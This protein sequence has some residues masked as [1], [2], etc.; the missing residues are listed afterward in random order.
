[1]IQQNSVLGKTKVKSQRHKV[2]SQMKKHSPSYGQNNQLVHGWVVVHSGQTQI[3]CLDCLAGHFVGS[4]LRGE[5]LLSHVVHFVILKK[6][7]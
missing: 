3:D 6:N 5:S 1:M 7:Y 2:K 4:A